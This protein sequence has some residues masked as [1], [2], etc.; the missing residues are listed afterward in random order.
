MTFSDHSTEC[1]TQAIYT[2][3]KCSILHFGGTLACFIELL[4]PFSPFFLMPNNRHLSWYL[5]SFKVIKLARVYASLVHKNDMPKT[6]VTVLNV[7]PS[8]SPSLTQTL[9]RELKPHTKTEWGLMS[10]A[11]QA[12]FIFLGKYLNIF[13]M[14]TISVCV[15][16]LAG[17]SLGAD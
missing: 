2:I 6:V 13:Q 5:L 8:P 12:K 7:C 15:L 1:W 9:K 10:S 16:P 4:F 11:L 14:A 17:R 3:L